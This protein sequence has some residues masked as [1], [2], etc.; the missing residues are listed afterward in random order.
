MCDKKF[1]ALRKMTCCFTGHRVIPQKDQI[2]LEQRLNNQITDLINQGIVYFGAGDALGF[3][4]L[5]AQVVIK[6]RKS[7]PHIKLILVLP[8]ETQADRWNLSD[9]KTY[10]N[11]KHRA[12]KI[13]YIS[14]QYTNNCM[15]I[16]NRHLVDNSSKC[17]CYLIREQGGTAYTVNYAKNCGLEIIN[18]SSTNM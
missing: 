17:V 7:Y 4:T 8:C 12:D 5:A 3:D 2:S 1:L 9:K 15:F 6:L 16:R 10:D 11:I 13:V 14:K 18:L